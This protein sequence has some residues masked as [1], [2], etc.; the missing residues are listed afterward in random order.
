LEETSIK[1]TGN[2]NKNIYGKALKHSLRKALEINHKLP[3]E[4][5]SMQGMSGKKYRSFINS[6]IEYLPDPRYLEI[7]SWKGSTACAAIYGNK[8]SAMC[9][10]NWSEFSGTREIFFDNVRRYLNSSIS[11]GFIEGD[12]RKIDYSALNKFNVFLFDGPHLEIDHYDG[13]IMP[14]AA[15]DDEYIIIVDDYNWP[16]VRNGTSKA[17]ANL[18][19]TIEC[20][21]EVRTTHDNS[22][23]KPSPREDGISD[24]HNGYFI[25]SV[26]KHS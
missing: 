3:K 16:D 7:G 4:L 5:L 9:I 17:I 11:F 1:L 14:Q 10:D 22:H 6:L 25:A 8:I 26:N 21:I 19:V 15:L 12:F 20:S 13:I 24:W 18:N 23:P 2:F